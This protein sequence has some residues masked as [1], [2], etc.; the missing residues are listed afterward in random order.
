MFSVVVIALLSAGLWQMVQGML[1]EGEVTVLI[2]LML[3]L[4][5]GVG[6]LT[7]IALANLD[8]TEHIV[9]GFSIMFAEEEEESK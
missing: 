3:E 5:R 8:G 1:I 7:L 9:E 4:I 2:A 6:R